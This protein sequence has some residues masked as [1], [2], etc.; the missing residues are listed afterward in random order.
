MS[1][2]IPMRGALLVAALFNFG[3]ALL[4]ALPTTLGQLVALPSAP[5]IYTTLVALF[6]ALFGA[7]YAWLALVRIDRTLLAL[8]AIGKM[9]AASAFFML[10]RTGDASL[11]LMLGGLGDLAFAAIFFWWL[12]ATAPS[13]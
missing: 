11:L 13:P 3:A 4:F 12:R 6:V 9:S 8:G 2:K 10:W 1:K 5:P 7:S